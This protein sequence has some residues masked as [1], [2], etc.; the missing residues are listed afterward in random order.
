MMHMNKR[1][2]LFIGFIL[3]FVCATAQQKY[4]R[5]SYFP[6]YK[7][8]IMAGYQG[9]FNAPA[10]GAEMGWNHYATNGRF[11]PGYCKVDFWPDVKEYKKTYETPF[12]TADGRPAYI[13]SS[14]DQAVRFSALQMDETV[15][16]GRCFYPA[17]GDCFKK[18]HQPAS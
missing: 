17:L 12:K 15:R 13:F 6:S 9:W 3:L 2:K 10:D 16:G 4:S 5:G 18:Q 14:Y 8:L 1:Q 11:E 7:G